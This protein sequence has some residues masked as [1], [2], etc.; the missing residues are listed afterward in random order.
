MLGA[1]LLVFASNAANN[2]LARS[3]AET[4]VAAIKAF[5]QQN[6]RYPTKLDELVP[7]F[8]DHVPIAKY[9]FIPTS[10]RFGR[11]YYTVSP[12]RH[13]LMYTAMPPFGRPYYQFEESKWKYMD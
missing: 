7:D 9:I 3:R 4:L 13:I 1:V 10:G 2:H 5:Y 12:E 8:I 11:F 6:Q